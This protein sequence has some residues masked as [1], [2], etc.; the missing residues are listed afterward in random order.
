MNYKEFTREDLEKVVHSY[1]KAFNKEPWNDKW[2]Y[3]T[4]FKRLSMTMN[5]QGFYGLIAS[6][7]NEFLGAIIGNEEI[8][9]DGINFNIK[10][11]WTNYEVESRGIGSKLLEELTKRLNEKDIRNITLFT[12]R[13]D[14]A[15]GF[16]ERRG[17]KTINSIVYMQKNIIKN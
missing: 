6:E 4:A 12:T 14:K 7:N 11:F 3:E 9:Y 1:I 17:F 15:E 5:T 16:Y 10:E 13:D 2:T 8:Y